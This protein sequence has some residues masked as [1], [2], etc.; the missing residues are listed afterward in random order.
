MDNV[1][2]PA[3][4]QRGG[5]E[6]IEVIRAKLGPQGFGYYCEG[7]VLKYLTRW[8][9]KNGLE[10]LR[11]AGVYLDWLITEATLQAAP[12]PETDGFKHGPPIDPPEH[13][14]PPIL[15]VVEAQDAEE[16]GLKAGEASQC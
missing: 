15:E 12:K 2:K 5:I 7:N 3:H 11:K 6:T 10:D 1:T 4:Y 13:A 16:M 14:P 8:R 9:D